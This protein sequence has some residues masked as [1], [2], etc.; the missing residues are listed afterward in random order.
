MASV[1]P[2]AAIGGLASATTLVGSLSNLLLASPQTT[3]GYKP[4]NNSTNNGLISLLTPPPSLLFHYEG[5]Q[6]TTF[7][8]DI[9]DH[10]IEDNTALQDQIALKPIIITTHGFIG[11][12]N[13]VPPPAL[14]ALQTAANA[15]VDIGSF[16]PGLSV[17]AQIA[18]D[19]AF[20]AYQLAKTAVTTAVAA[21]SS[22]SSIAGGGG[23]G[24]TVFGSGGSVTTK[25]S[26][27]NLQQSYFQQLY[28][29]WQSRTLFTVQ[30]PW[31]IF[32][33]MA[34]LT[35]RAVQDET[36]KTITD[37]EISFKQINIASTAL[38]G[39][40]LQG[41]GRNATAS[42]DL[43]SN[44]SGSLSAGPSVGQGIANQLGVGNVFG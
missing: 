12:L 4:Q 31:A 18:Y 39:S 38:L 14:A 17:T 28:G 15:L 20:A 5:E 27:Q 23:G 40:L 1:S 3:Q 44:G 10:F 19:E 33:N 29:Y 25:I 8:S 21:V 35:C 24:E 43:E 11:E 9:T 41:S 34:I 6:T 30:T 2:I 42:A 36:T 26:S 37:F 7:S 16:V 13:N 32:Q 22:I